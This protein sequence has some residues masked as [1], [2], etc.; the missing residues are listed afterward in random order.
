MNAFASER[1]RK[2]NCFSYLKIAAEFEQCSDGIRWL[3]NVNILKCSS[4]IE[5]SKAVSARVFLNV[6]IKFERPLKYV[7]KTKK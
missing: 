1:K 7:L 3:E 5:E 4:P 6:K 2:L